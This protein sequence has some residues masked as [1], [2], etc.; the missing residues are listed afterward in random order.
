MMWDGLGFFGFS[1]TKLERIKGKKVTWCTPILSWK[2]CPFLIVLII[3]SIIIIK[4]GGNL[5]ELKSQTIDL[6][7][8]E[9]FT[10]DIEKALP[11]I[12]V[13]FFWN[14]EVFPKAREF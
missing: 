9:S 3:F 7:Q 2:S 6:K 8:N 13:N 14:D 4:E 11:L 12:G 10:Y 5:G 1:D